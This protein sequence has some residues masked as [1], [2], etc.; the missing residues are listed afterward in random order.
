MPSRRQCD[1]SR[2]SA[3][4]DRCGDATRRRCARPHDAAH[5]IGRTRP[6]STGSTGAAVPRRAAQRPRAAGHRG[7]QTAVALA[8]HPSSRL[9]SGGPRDIVCRRRGGRDLRADRA[10]VLRRLSRSSRGGARRRRRAAA[11]Q[12]LHRRRVSTRGSRRVRRRCR[13]ADRRGAGRSSAAHASG[14]DERIRARGA[15]GSARSRGAGA[16]A[17]RGGGH[18]RCEQSQSA[19]VDRGPGGAGDGGG[20]LARRRHRRGGEWNPLRRRHLST[21]RAW[22]SRVPRRRAADCRR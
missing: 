3:R 9:P 11:A 14:G 18:R 7:V 17:R 8:R 6:P 22:L 19:H 5:G 12:G 13:V 21:I 16:R 1:G 4:D 20:G 2:G 10:H 15:G